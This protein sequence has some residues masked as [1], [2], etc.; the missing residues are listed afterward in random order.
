MSRDTRSSIESML[1]EAGV[2]PKYKRYPVFYISDHRAFKDVHAFAP[3]LQLYDGLNESFHDAE[4]NLRIEFLHLPG[5]G[6]LQAQLERLL[7][8]RPGGVVLDASLIDLAETARF[9]EKNQVPVVQ[10]GHTVRVDGIDAVVVDSFGGAYMAIRHF[11]TAGHRRIGIARWYVHGDPASSKKFAGYQCALSE[12]GIP[13][14]DEYVVE[15]PF[16]R[17]GDHLPGRV[18]VE[19]LLALP[20]PPTAVF[21]ENSFISPSLLFTTHP[22]ELEIPKAIR[23]LDIIHFEAW[24]LEWLNQVLAQK[25]CYTPLQAKLIRIDWKELGRVA[26][27]RLAVRMEGVPNSGQIVQLVPSL[28]EAKSDEYTPI[29]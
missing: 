8:Y 1:R 7:S 23:D 25:L 27:K 21:I 18:A 16:T 22:H 3:F 29:P 28:F 17:E 11:I 14:R 5:S 2:R 4:V 15:S 9:F 12:A 19:K 20:E 6:A 10:V 13:M 26:A 24:H